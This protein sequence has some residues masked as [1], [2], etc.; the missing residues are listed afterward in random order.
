MW[1]QRRVTAH[2]TRLRALTKLGH[3]R[4][5]Q[6]TQIQI[7]VRMDTK[8]IVTQSNIVIQRSVNQCLVAITL[9]LSVTVHVERNGF[10]MMENSF[11]CLVEVPLL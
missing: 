4:P 11:L 2:N 7:H 10:K 9:P 6:K 3:Q 8:F 1:Q 5:G